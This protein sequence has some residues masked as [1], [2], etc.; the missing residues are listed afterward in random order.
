MKKVIF[1]FAMLLATVACSEKQTANVEN[2]AESGE[3]V[4]EVAKNYFFKK[5][6]HYLLIPRLLRKKIST[7]SSV[8]QLQ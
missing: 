3:V 1:A 2:N 6:A 5:I 8:W 4:F 7:N